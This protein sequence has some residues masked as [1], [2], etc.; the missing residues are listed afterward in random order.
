MNRLNLVLALLGWFAPVAASQQ[1]WVVDD[2][3]GTG[4]DFSAIQGAI[5]AAVDGDTILVRAGEQPAFVVDGKS[6][7]VTA[8]TGAAVHVA[9]FRV[10]NLAVDQSATIIGLSAGAPLSFQPGVEVLK[11]TDCAGPVLIQDCVFGG[12]TQ[13]ALAPLLPTVTI[14]NASAVSFERCSLFGRTN[15]PLLGAVGLLAGALSSHASQ[16]QFAHSSVTGAPGHFALSQ[17]V[18]LTEATP[19]EKAIELSASR[20]VLLGSGVHGGL[21]GDGTYHTAAKTCTAGAAG[22]TAVVFGD[23]AC[24]L[25]MRA[26]DL[27]GGDGGVAGIDPFGFFVCSNGTEGAATTG[28][29]LLTSLP[30]DSQMLDLMPAVVREGGAGMLQLHGTPGAGAL[31]LVSFDQSQ[32]WLPAHAGVLLPSA[33]LLVFPVGAVPGSGTLALPYTAPTLPAGIDGLAVILQSA[34]TSGGTGGGPVI[35]GGSGALVILDATL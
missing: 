28:P 12:N 5:N 30:G 33:E 22:G 25:I 18:S 10:R 2:T 26:S 21:G 6:L 23:A 14:N 3:A 16:V 8:D 29:G 15:M 13:F 4:A 34:F 35:L 9:G 19:G 32:L 11:V 31:L 7:T 1:V 17:G 24:E 20:L 27:A